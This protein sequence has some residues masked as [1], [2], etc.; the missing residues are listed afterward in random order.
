[1]VLQVLG[2]QGQQRGLRVLLGQQLLGLW[3]LGL[4]QP[5]WLGLLVLGQPQGQLGPVWPPWQG[6]H[7]QVPGIPHWS[8]QGQVW[9][10]PWL[11]WGKG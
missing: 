7:L 10:T 8:T 2:H 1:M 9:Y 11:W 3:L 5:P 4:V 6:L